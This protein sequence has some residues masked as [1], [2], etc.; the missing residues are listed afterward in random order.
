MLPL[1]MMLLFVYLGYGQDYTCSRATYYGSPDC[2]GNPTGACGYGEYGRTV[3]NGYVAGVHR[4]YRN[5]TG[6]GGCYQVRCKTGDC[7]D[8]GV[9]VVATDFGVGDWTDFLFTAKAYAKMARPGLEAQLL[10]YGV[11]DIEYRRVPCTFRGSNL[12]V[13]VHEGTKYPYYFAITI[14]YPM[15]LY[16]VV[17]VQIWQEDCQEWRPMRKPF[18]A[19]WDMENPP[20]GGGAYRIRF[21]L[22]ISGSTNDAT[23]VESPTPIPAYWKAGANYELTIKL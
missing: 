22:S 9:V 13:T 11:V 20:R 2:L 17:G 16:D 10:S 5:G 3:N 4:P 1:I 8:D 7:T 19:V 6:C 15:G 21:L 18:G 12:I 23:W 14:V